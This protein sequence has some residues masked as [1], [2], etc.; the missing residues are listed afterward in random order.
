MWRAVI[1]QALQDAVAIK[2]IMR[3]G[4][5]TFASVESEKACHW[6]W[7]ADANFV[8]MCDCADLD[9]SAVAEYAQDVIHGGG[10]RQRARRLGA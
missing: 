10:W 3:E 6:F 1:D 7:W 2:R 5:P 9:G 4:R 8:L